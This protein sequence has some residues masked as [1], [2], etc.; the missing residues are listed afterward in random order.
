MTSEEYL[1]KYIPLGSFLVEYMNFVVRGVKLNRRES[2]IA[3]PDTHGPDNSNAKTR[4]VPTAGRA[5]RTL[6]VVS[7]NG[8]S[9][10]R[11]TRFD[12]YVAWGL[13][14]AIHTTKTESK[15]SNNSMT[16]KQETGCPPSPCHCQA[17]PS[18]KPQITPSCRHIA[19][20][21]SSLTVK[22]DALSSI[23]N[24]FSLSSTDLTCSSRSL[25][26]DT[27]RLHPAFLDSEKE[28]NTSPF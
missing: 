9:I 15:R 7:V 14:N 5:H 2:Q 13:T 23:S 8:S 18:R 6:S 20:F 28:K 22:D 25:Y 21:D 1:W 16:K 10:P 26:H 11:E 3:S 19:A 12:G 27:I 24:C 4:I 17:T